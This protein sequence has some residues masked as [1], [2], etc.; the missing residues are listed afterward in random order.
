VFCTTTRAVGSLTVPRTVTGD[1]GI[2]E[3]LAGWIPLS[4]NT[5]GPVV[6]VNVNAHGD[7]LEF[8]ATSAAWT[9]IELTPCTRVNAHWKLPPLDV[10]G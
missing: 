5:G 8:P 9:E 6:G 7:A 4:V 10:P 3:P 1:C 2:T